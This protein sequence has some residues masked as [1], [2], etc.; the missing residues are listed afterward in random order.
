MEQ[1]SG[2]GLRLLSLDGGGI[3]GISEL[4]I[5]KEVM[6][7]VQKELQLPETPKPCDVFDLIGGTSTGG[8]I[9]MLL[10]R[11]QLSVA[12]AE[13]EYGKLSEQIFTKKKGPGHEGQFSATRLEAEVKQV[14]EKYGARAGGA[15]TELK[16]VDATLQFGG[17]KVFVCTRSARA[18]NTPRLFRS[19]GPL[20]AGD[21]QDIK[22]WQAARATSA[23]PRFFKRMRIGPKNLQEEF[24]DG[25]MGANN[26]TKLLMAEA[27]R[28]FPQNQPVSCIL[29]I[30]CGDSGIVEYRDPSFF[31]RILP[32]ELVR[33]LADMITDCKATAMEVDEKFRNTPDTYFRFNVDQGLQ[34]VGLEEWKE[35]GA[36]ISKTESYLVGVKHVVARAVRALGSAGNVPQLTVGDLNLLIC[37]LQDHGLVPNSQ[38]PMRDENVSAS[39]DESELRVLYDS[40][41]Y[42][43]MRLREKRVERNAERAQEDTFDWIFESEVTA[44]EQGASETIRSTKSAFRT[45]CRGEGSLFWVSGKAASGKST[46]MRKTYYDPRLDDCLKVWASGESVTKASMFFSY[47]GTIL[48]RSYEGLWRSLLHETLEDPVLRARVLGPYLHKISPGATS[49][50]SDIRWTL[51]E[52]REV[53]T[54]LLE[55]ANSERRFCFFIDG[56]DEYSALDANYSQPPGYHL[57]I[58]DE[59]GRKIRA[60]YLEIAHQIQKMSKT[61]FVKICVSSRPFNEFEVAFKSLPTFKL[62]FLT[63]GDIG[64]YVHGQLTTHGNPGLSAAYEDCTQMIISKAQGVFLWV[65]IAV[66]IL[67]DG[68][69][70]GLNPTQLLISMRGL[71]S[72]LGGAKGL[73]MRQL[74]KLGP[75]YLA[76]TMSMFDIVFHARQELTLLV[77]SFALDYSPER[78]IQLLP[79][80]LPTADIAHRSAMME[81]RL[82]SCGGLLAIY[83]NPEEL[84][85]EKRSDAHAK[86]LPVVRFMH[87][88]LQEFL[89]RPD[90]QLELRAIAGAPGTDVHVSL[91]TACLLRLQLIGVTSDFQ[92]V[93]GAIKDG[94]YYAAQAEESTALSQTGLL[95]DLDKVVTELLHAYMGADDTGDED[96]YAVTTFKRRFF[97]PEPHCYNWVSHEP[98]ESGG[99]RYEWL[100]NFQSLCV[101]ANLVL[102]LRAQVESL[103][104]LPDKPGRP[105]LAYAVIPTTLYTILQYGPNPDLRGTGISDPAVTR[106]LLESGSDPNMVYRDSQ[107]IEE[108]DRITDK[109]NG[110]IWQQ[111]L[112]A[113]WKCHEHETNGRPSPHRYAEWDWNVWR[114]NMILLIDFGAD[115]NAV[116]SFEG[117][118]SRRE[119]VTWRSSVLLLCLVLEWIHLEHSDILAKLLR[120]RGGTL[121]KAEV[122]ENAKHFEECGVPQS[123]YSQWS[124]MADKPTETSWRIPFIGKLLSSNAA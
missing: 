81:S 7:G 39:H 26:P 60:G 106:L 107:S 8:L 56:L 46:L 16:L 109:A 47:E 68:I 29:S 117:R 67:L 96:S 44:V 32:L 95:E 121:R 71:P 34:D 101:Q 28:I 55:E 50:P 78:A 14:V 113:A 83:P 52:L 45:W 115:P 18:L 51:H 41:A 80:R 31:Q 65:R 43:S 62:Q 84:D 74:K 90:I 77:L 33:A 10:G 93:W 30:G 17:C 59:N 48:Q 25:G 99:K 82:R 104:K 79:Q 112:A 38:L 53:L 1:Q 108:N 73:Y 5:L 2:R 86:R 110:S 58:D 63:T 15:S 123:V 91:L 40:L 4:F 97:E 54:K 98:Q 124:N 75:K 92:D 94:L 23:A 27:V 36:I 72:E 24:V 12:E 122:V 85:R 100:D 64:K 69:L 118:I 111:A 19:Y 42:D 21:Y 120:E 22:I 11:L 20:G 13:E 88:T 103:G 35:M 9:A 102:Y 61:R 70:N 87:L 89:L 114:A 116:V 105:L 57:D 3:R 6:L 119:S 37:L 66:D 49:R 76:Q